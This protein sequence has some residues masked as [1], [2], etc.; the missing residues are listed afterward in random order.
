MAVLTKT[1][2]GE[3]AAGLA[4]DALAA[5][6][7]EEWGAALEYF[8][9]ARGQVAAINAA[10][11]YSII[12]G[13]PQEID[14]RFSSSLTFGLEI[15]GHF[16][17]R[18]VWGIKDVAEKLNASRSTTHRYMTTLVL[19]GQLEQTVGRKYRRPEIEE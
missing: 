18:E 12:T 4:E 6:A 8:D 2:A 16:S 14:R 17:G 9:A 3:R 7:A 1:E 10:P 11:E 5:L 15:L 13:A 19:L